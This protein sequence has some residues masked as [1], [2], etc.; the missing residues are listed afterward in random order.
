MVHATGTICLY[1][2]FAMKHED[3]TMQYEECVMWYESALYNM[4][5]HY[6]IWGYAMWYE[7]A[8]IISVRNMGALG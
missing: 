6:V 7:C 4:K 8:M 3:C 5:M 1:N 2:I